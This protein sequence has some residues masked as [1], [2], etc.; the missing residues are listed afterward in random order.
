MTSRDCN[1][2]QFD[3]F[4]VLSAER[5]LIFLYAYCA[6]Q[7]E[8]LCIPV[9]LLS[10][11]NY[12]FTERPQLVLKINTQQRK[13]LSTKLTKDLLESMFSQTAK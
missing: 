10:P 4:A 9:S 7:R 8:S 5:E 11:L 6:L 3:Y 2:V 12:K 13:A 1:I